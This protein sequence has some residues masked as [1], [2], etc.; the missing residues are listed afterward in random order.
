MKLKSWSAS[1]LLCLSMVLLGPRPGSSQELVPLEPQ[2]LRDMYADGW[3]KVEEGVLRRDGANGKFETF[4]YGA[5]GIQWVIQGYEQQIRFLQE[6]YDASPTEELGEVIGRLK[7]RVDRLSGNLGSAPAAESFDGETATACGAIYDAAASADPQEASRGVTATASAFFHDNCGSVADTF[8][9]AYAEAIDGTVHTVLTQDDPKQ[10]GWIDSY[11]TASA[12]GS[13]GCH[14]YAQADVSVNGISIR[15]AGDENSD[16]PGALMASILGPA[17]VTTDSYGSSCAD[18]TWTASASE[19]NPGY[20]YTWYI[21]EVLQGTGPSLTQQYCSVDKTVTVKVIAKD[22]LGWTDDATFETAIQHNAPVVASVRGPATVVTDHYSSPCAD[23]TW[24]ASATGGHPGYT[25]NWYVDGGTTIQGTGSSFTQNYCNTSKTVSVRVVVQ[26][27]DGHTDDATV[28]T[29]V[30]HI[31][32]IVA[33]VS[34]PASVTTDYYSSPCADVTWTAS[35]G[36]GSSGYTYSWYIGTDP[37]IQGTSSTLTKRYCNTGQTVTVKVV[38]RDSGGHTDE[39]PFT[40]VI[41]Y[42]GPVTASVSGSST[43]TTDYYTSTCADVTWTASASG[44]HPGYTYSWYLGTGTTVQGTGKSFTKNYCSTNQSV[45]ARVVVRDSDGHTAEDT[46]TTTLKHR[47]AITASIS[48][49]SQVSTN[50]STPCAD[51]TWTA[52]ASSSGHTGFTYKWYI[53]TS[54]QG[55]GS[56]LTKRYCSTSQSVTVKVIADASEDTH[57]DDATFTT[58]I[59]HIPTPPTASISGPATVQLATAGEC[60]SITWTASATGGASP[61]T[62]SW[63]IGT[64]TT[65]QSTASTLT[66]SYCGAQTVN[67]KVVVR[68]TAGQT[69]DATFTTTLVNAA[70]AVTIDG[71]ETVMAGGGR[72]STVTLYANVTGGTPGYTYSWYLGT[73]TTVVGTGSSYTRNVCN[74]GFTAKVTV[75]DAGAKTASATH[76]VG[77]ESAC[78]AAC[79]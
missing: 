77:V 73:S 51:V 3:Q 60:K 64:S 48:G 37:T 46:R 7:A 16:C 17:D 36:G 78:F 40:T 5:E 52:S 53:G 56:T 63:Y 57:T 32:P 62:Y 39:E 24:T 44:G 45:T 74:A 49:P 79:P 6:K 66:K 29:D 15:G 43:V 58:T 35:A 69:D 54:L 70:L 38:A 9:L 22:T 1:L 20:T 68:D 8:V 12:L 33:S 11:A 65:V 25:Y 55:S 50:S 27:S 4:S 71:P 30:Q 72:C 2:W 41:Q 42:T 10:G 75:R 19:G 13:S 26:D 59:T 18:V 28:T 31:Q 47:G 34:G 23:V 76:T 21:D 61:Y 14:S 67:V